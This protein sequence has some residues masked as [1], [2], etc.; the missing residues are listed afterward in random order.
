M[1]INQFTYQHRRD[2]K[3][4]FECEHCH[5][6]YEDWGYDDANYHNNVLPTIKCPKCG[7]TSKDDYRPLQ[8]LYP[9][10]FQI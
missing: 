9:E 10:G 1:R 4:I 6:I 5:N 2:F 3:A 7:L 8:P